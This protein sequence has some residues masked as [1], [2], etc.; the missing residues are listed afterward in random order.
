MKRQNENLDKQTN[1]YKLALSVDVVLKFEPRF[2]EPNFKI[3]RSNAA[4]ALLSKTK[5]DEAEDIFDFFDTVGLFVKLGAL[6]L[7]Q[8][9]HISFGKAV[10]NALRAPL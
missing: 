5:E 7:Q 9:H 3:I 6:T 8:F 1:A 4:R 10:R 2:N